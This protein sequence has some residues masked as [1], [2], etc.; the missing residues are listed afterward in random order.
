MREFTY[1]SQAAR[2]LFGA[3]TLARLREELERLSCS[4]AVVLTTAGQADLA[5]R[6]RELLGP[7]AAGAFT[8]A[9]MHT[10]TAV[11]EQALALVRE[12][13]ADCVVAIGG[14]STTGLSKALAVRTGLPQIVVPTTYAGSE[15]T[16]VLGETDNGVKTTRSSPAILP[17]T[18]VYDVDLTL[19]LPVPLSV[20]S[21]VNAMAHA[22]EALYAPQA[23]PVTDELALRSIALMSAALPR[24]AEDPADLESRADA[25]QAA[26]LA[27]TCLGTV[28]MGLH[29]KLCHTLGGSFGLPHA[30]THTVVLPHAMAYNARA[31]PDV[32]RRI[33][34]V[35]GAAD[36]PA[37]V[38]D[39]VSALHGPVSLG[40]LGLREEDLAKAAE[41]AGGASYP[42]P[43]EVTADGVA[44]LLRDAWE[45]RRPASESRALPTTA[46]RTLTDQVVASFD[47][48]PDPRV[49]R[50][51]ADLV[52]RLHGFV[53][54]NDLTEDEWRYA[55]GFLTRTGQL[56]SDTRQ[57]FI[58]LSDTLGVSSAVDLLT[59]SRT[60]ESTP[61]A[62]LGP[63]YVEGPPPLPGGADISQGLAGTPL[64]TSVRITGT[65]GTALPD[66]VVD[67][68]QSNDDGFYDV[69][70]PDLDGPALRARFR[71]DAE[72]RVEFWS[73]LPSAYPIPG[74]GPVG[75]MLD[76]A[77]RH[78]YRAPHLHF[79]IS[80][81]GR[82][83]LI[84][85]L[86]VAGGAY[87]DSDTVFGVK[88]ALIVDFPERGGPTPDGRA[89]DGPWHSLD[90]TFRLAPETPR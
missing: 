5:A 39:L 27:G 69:Q 15:V 17:E 65:D 7:L 63:F 52:R 28:G 47:G 87:Q 46:L 68:W 75:Q 6:A 60:A 43:R 24:I 42:N 55:I 74:D 59:N 78:H 8:G 88:D 54:D 18:V 50:L 77:G 51:L 72:G 40:G 19:G 30:E 4:R 76:A 11:T 10:P 82:Q 86:F 37:A 21:G 89:L 16:P 22:V 49:R 1:V 61:S 20:T 66:A 58:L 85:Q 48:A 2:V 67:V 71:S 13:G 41:L 56:S 3:G 81:P 83:R 33:A 45:G 23:D 9:A 64:W 35:L 38:Y 84:T 90:Y 79:M 34:E 31:V 14:G 44:A 53:A 29:H 36:A 32:M 73:I 25:L 57:E 80:A 12:L 26:W 62:V 70:L